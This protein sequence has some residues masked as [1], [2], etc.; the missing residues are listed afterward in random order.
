[1]KNSDNDNSEL[2]A[3]FGSVLT[4]ARES[5]NYTVDDICQ[6][7]KIPVQS[8]TALENN[9]LDAL[10]GPAFT[11]G[12]LRTYAKFLEIPE[13]SVLELYNRAAP[14]EGNARLK[15][16]SNLP[17]EAS[18]QSPLVKFVTILLIIA[19]LITVI[20]GSYQYYQKKAGVMETELESKQSSFT[21]S[22]LD[23]PASYNDSQKRDTESMASEPAVTAFESSE[24]E[25][26]LASGEDTVQLE[27]GQTK[28]LSD[29]AI[30][31]AVEDI[32][33]EQ[34]DAV[35]AATATDE[36]QPQPADSPQD[37]LEIY[38]IQGAWLQVKDASNKRLFYNMVPVRGSRKLVGQ[39]PF[40]VT[41][42]NA[43]TTRVTINELEVDLSEVIR[44][45]NTAV[46]SVS[47]EDQNVILR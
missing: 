34:P 26:L 31:T 30:D 3:D 2:D 47:T 24:T 44:A 1:M 15:P 23:Y 36:D 21:G 11:Q 35:E 22:S 43:S 5:K 14:Q 10:P 42:G 37:V 46:F 4:A 16:R 19:G 8:I 33:T 45:K 13:D 38:A 25:I 41:L 12:Y 18:S 29:N 7:L 27:S 32:N 20:F 39:A 9:D 40:R 6:Q 17:G 28:D